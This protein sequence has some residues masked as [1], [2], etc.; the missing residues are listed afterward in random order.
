M[1]DLY[2][3]IIDE[4]ARLVRE[5]NTLEDMADLSHSPWQAANFQNDA[6]ILKERIDKLHGL[7]PNSSTINL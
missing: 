4:I 7:L 1:T 6:I 2:F 3:I 5:V